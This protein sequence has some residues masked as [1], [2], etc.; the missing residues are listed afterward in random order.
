MGSERDAM[1]LVRAE[2]CERLDQIGRIADRG[3]DIKA[4]IAALSR[5]AASYGLVPVVR[6]ADAFERSCARSGRAPSAPSLFVERLADAIGCA[7]A[8]EAAS[9]AML[10]SVAIRT[11]G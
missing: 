8:D 4:Q 2:L 3:G 11:G 5:M 6:I 7:S 9:Q 1:M 10:A